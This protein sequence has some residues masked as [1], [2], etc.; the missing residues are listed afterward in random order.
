VGPQWLEPSGVLSSPGL[1]PFSF[2]WWKRRLS[3]GRK[4]WVEAVSDT[5]AKR[6]FRAHFIEVRMPDVAGPGAMRSGWPVTGLSVCRVT[7][8]RLRS[9]G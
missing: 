5:E 2:S 4:R 9:R 7:S 3:A 8:R 1:Q 6:P